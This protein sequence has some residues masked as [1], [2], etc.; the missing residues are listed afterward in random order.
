LAEVLPTN[1]FQRE[2]LGAQRSCAS[3]ADYRGL[4]FLTKEE[5]SADILAHP[6]FGTNLTYPVEAY[7]RY[8]QTSGTTGAPLRVLDTPATW[9]WF[10]RCWLEVLRI[11][12]VTAK[13]Q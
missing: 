5:L 2:K 6:P 4:P 12:G 13:D 10:G 9:D 8:H 3:G 7:T 1:R 11:A